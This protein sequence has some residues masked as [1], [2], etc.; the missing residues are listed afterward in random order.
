MNNTQTQ[1]EVRQFDRRKFCAASTVAALATLAGPRARAEVD[2]TREGA[3]SPTM[4]TGNGEW[5]YDVVAGWGQLPAATVFGG[6]H[7]AIATDNAGH[8]Y[9]STQSETGI[10]VYTADAGR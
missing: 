6:T 10:L 1:P 2:A 3:A 5:T 8:V 4:R 7:G 9:V